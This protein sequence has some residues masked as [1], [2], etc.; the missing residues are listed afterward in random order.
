MNHADVLAA[1]RAAGLEN[2]R[3]ILV[4]AHSADKWALSFEMYAGPNDLALRRKEVVAVKAGG[5]AV[6]ADVEAAI[7]FLGAKLAV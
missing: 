5:K 6:A 2:P 3:V 7:S 4:R 1:M